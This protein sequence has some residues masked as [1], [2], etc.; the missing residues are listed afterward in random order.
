MKRQTTETQRHRGSTEKTQADYG[1]SCSSARPVLSSLCLC[2]SVVFF[3]P[4]QWLNWNSRELTSTQ[5]RSWMPS[6]GEAALVIQPAAL[7]ASSGRGGR[8]SVARYSSS[9]IVG[10]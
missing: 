7:A 8:D 6:R 4:A 5:R 1:G 9:T 10:T 2:A 3:V